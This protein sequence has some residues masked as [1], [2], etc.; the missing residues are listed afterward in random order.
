MCAVISITVNSPVSIL[1]LENFVA[2]MEGHFFTASHDSHSHCVAIVVYVH[3]R[4]YAEV[5]YDVINEAV[6]RVLAQHP[7]AFIL[8]NGDFNHLRMKMSSYLSG[9]VQ[10]VK[11]P[12]REERTLDLFFANA[13]D[14]YFDTALPPLG[15]SDHNLVLL[16]RPPGHLEDGHLKPRRHS[17]LAS[18]GLIGR[19]WRIR[20]E[21]WGTPW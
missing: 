18:N 15:K 16:Q 3:P 19:Y 9:F 17:G 20:R 7:E 21:T 4:A 8:I 6:A 10:Y 11:C 14:A 1:I 12:T 13:K 2:F 5:A